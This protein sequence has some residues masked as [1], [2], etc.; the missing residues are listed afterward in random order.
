MTTLT[1][2]TPILLDPTN[3]PTLSDLAEL[4]GVPVRRCERWPFDLEA[5]SRVVSTVPVPHAHAATTLGV[6][7]PTSPQPGAGETWP[8]VTIPLDDGAE[9]VIAYLA[10]AVTDA[11]EAASG[12][13]VVGVWG[14]RG[15][16]GTSTLAAALARV[17]AE[18]PLAVALV[19]ADPVSLVWPHVQSQGRLAWAD[20]AGES[21]PLLPHRLDANLPVWH[22]V[23]VLAADGRGSVPAVGPAVGALA[24]THDVV[25]VDSGR[26]AL[27]GARTRVPVLTGTREEV[28]ALGRLVAERGEAERI[29][30]VVRAG[31]EISAREVAHHCD[32]PVVHL[33]SERGSSAAARHGM[34][35]GDRPRGAVARAAR[36]VAAQLDVDG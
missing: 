13:T 35:P 22:R 36:A 11:A 3:D 1:C 10:G 23:R 9:M 12:A 6:L 32:V 26:V 33:G 17:I 15:G 18:D 2:D 4:A 25:V 31:G 28:E 8:E 14:L 34:A 19:D 30:P 5:G 21:G 27:P 16:I 29:V 24:T 7:T 20:L